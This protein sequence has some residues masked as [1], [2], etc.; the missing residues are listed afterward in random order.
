MKLLSL[1]LSVRERT[2]GA[3]QFCMKSSSAKRRNS[4]MSAMALAARGEREPSGASIHKPGAAG[5]HLGDALIPI[6][7]YL[8]RFS[9][10]PRRI[11]EWFGLEGTRETIESWNGWVGKV[12][13]GPRITEWF[14]PPS[15]CQDSP[16][17]LGK[18]NLKTISGGASIAASTWRAGSPTW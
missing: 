1:V 14:P 11:E 8:G 6:L 12:L 3:V 4:Y 16:S 2:L 17:S 7:L 9:P 15:L 10:L 18:E 13:K 5:I